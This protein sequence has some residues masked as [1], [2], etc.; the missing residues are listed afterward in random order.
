MKKTHTSKRAHL[1]LGNNQTACCASR[2]CSRASSSRILSYRSRRRRR[3]SA[4]GRGLRHACICV[5]EQDKECDTP[6]CRLAE[7]LPPTT[8][9]LACVGKETWL[10]LQPKA[11]SRA[12]KRC[13]PHAL[14]SPSTT[15]VQ[16]QL[17]SRK[18]LLLWGPVVYYGGT[19]RLP[20]PRIP[21]QS[22]AP[23]HRCCFNELTNGLGCQHAAP[24]HRRV[25]IVHIQH[26]KAP[27]AADAQNI[28]DR[29]CGG[30]SL[31]FKHFG[32]DSFLPS[33]VV[34]QDYSLQTAKTTEISLEEHN[35]QPKSTPWGKYSF[36]AGHAE[37]L[38]TGE[39]IQY[40]RQKYKKKLKTASR[41]SFPE[42]CYIY[43]YITREMDT[44]TRIISYAKYMR[45][46][47]RNLSHRIAPVQLPTEPFTPSLL[48]HPR[49][50]N[51][52][53]T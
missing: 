51:V 20:N 46:S 1:A 16:I 14:S 24:I 12:Q 47:T 2:S 26:T 8:S 40:H 44:D 48:I 17:L 31:F 22:P 15:A 11:G 38:N 27:V 3:S 23:C 9:S 10:E 30:S 49:S 39:V 37:K 5:T 32:K 35:I 25:C 21:P 4:T 18:T 33:L 28:G 45:S 43:T 42:N 36:V 13:H 53:F 29:V 50:K 52:A 6:R 34:Q 7:R 19:Y 41:E